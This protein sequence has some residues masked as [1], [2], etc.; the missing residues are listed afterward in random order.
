MALGKPVIG[1]DYS[2]NTDF[3]TEK[4]GFPVS[5]RLVEVAPG[6]YPGGEGQVWADPDVEHAA[7]LMRQV[8]AG[9]GNAAE[10]ADAGRR[11]MAE[12]HSSA[13]VGKKCRDRLALLG[14]VARAVQ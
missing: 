9:D 2:G 13:A 11:Y 10:R 1:T 7:W 6:A 3:L 4:T 5:Y 14:L 8:V 12:N